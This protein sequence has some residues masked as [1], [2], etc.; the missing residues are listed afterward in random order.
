VAH[1]VREAGACTR[2]DPSLTHRVGALTRR[3]SEGLLHKSR[4]DALRRHA[5]APLSGA[6][7]VS[8]SRRAGTAER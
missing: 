2:V 3:V 5:A 1:L 4:A 6:F 7:V 8:L